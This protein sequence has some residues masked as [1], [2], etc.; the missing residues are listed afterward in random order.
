MLQTPEFTVSVLFRAC[1]EGITV[2]SLSPGA[3][4][5]KRFSCRG[6]PPAVKSEVKLE[7]LKLENGDPMLQRLISGA[8]VSTDALAKRLKDIADDAT[9][10]QV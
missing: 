3:L 9:E 1:F 7:A 10:V 2:N 6:F 8:S 4:S 5:Q